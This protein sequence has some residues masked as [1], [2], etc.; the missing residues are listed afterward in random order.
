MLNRREFLGSAAALAAPSRKPNFVVLYTDDQRFDTIRA[1]GNDEIRTPNMDRLAKRGVAFTHCF[2]QGGMHGAI[3]VPSRAQL[4]T[5]QTLW[6][7]NRNIVRLE[8]KT[9]PGPFHLFPELL[10]QQGYTTCGIG[11][12]HNQPAL[13]NRAYST[14]GPVFFGGMDD[15]FKTKLF[16]Y[17]PTGKYPKEKMRFSGKHSSETFAD[18]A[19]EFLK[20][21]RGA[22]DPFLCYVAFTSP[23]DPRTA[24]KPY[25]EWYDPAKIRLPKNFLPA[26]PF[27]NGDLKV[28]D[29]MLAAHPRTEA[30]VR[31]HIADYFAM[32]SEVDA[33]IG[34]ILDALDAS[35]HASNT[36]VIFA[37][38]NGLAVGRHGLFG[39]QNLYDHSWRVPLVISGPGIR[40]GQRAA[41]L[42]HIMDIC[43]TVL[44]LAG[45]PI[46]GTVDARSLSPLLRNPKQKHR[47]T[48]Y[49]AYRMFQRAIRDE[50]YKLIRYTVGGETRVQVFD[51]KDDPLEMRPLPARPELAARLDAEMRRLGD[52]LSS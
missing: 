19:V 17:D 30:E 31:R 32:V 48:V 9:P 5:G 43:P 23:H 41:G 35:G 42:C 13:F 47:E 40:G 45:V 27:D 37:G 8:V 51:L 34:R 18:A 21:R 10:R 28:R 1:L 15:Q 24:P 49:G 52:P 44:D 16:D 26:H 3:C 22:A 38:D 46:P 20:G 39:K 4:H 6:N 2:T 7:V 14:G 25:S 33:Q 12:W 29:E 11:K 36:H 50:R